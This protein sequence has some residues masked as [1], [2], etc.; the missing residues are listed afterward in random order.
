MQIDPVADQTNLIGD[1]VSVPMNAWGQSGQTLTYSATGLP[2]GLSIDSSTGLISGTIANNA[3]VTTPYNV[4]VTATDGT[5]P[6]S[7]T[8]VEILVQSGPT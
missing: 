4:T 1:S 2:P 3:S 5:D 7:T 8:F 6:A